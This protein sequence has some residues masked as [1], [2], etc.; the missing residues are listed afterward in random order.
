MTPIISFI[1]AAMLPVSCLKWKEKQ[2]ESKIMSAKGKSNT[3]LWIA[4]AVIATIVIAGSINSLPK[5]TLSSFNIGD[6]D[7]VTPTAVPTTSPYGDTDGT[8]PVTRKLQLSVNDF[9]AGTKLTSKTVYVYL[10]KTLKDTLTTD[11]TTGLAI[12]SKPWAS[13]TNLNLYYVDGNSKYWDPLEVPEMGYTDAMSSTYNEVSMEPFT[14]GTYSSDSLTQGGSAL[15]DTN[16]YNKTLSGNTPTFVYSLS[17]TGADN[18]GLIESYDPI[19]EIDLGAW[20]IV[21]LTGTDATK[22]VLRSGF[23]HSYTVGTD[24]Y[25]W[26]HV[27]PNL[28]SK[29]T[30]GSAYKAGYEG[31][32]S[33]SWSI[34][35]TGYSADTADM[36]VY[37]EMYANPTY[38]Q[39]HGGSFGPAAVE[40][41][42]QTINIII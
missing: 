37:F 32:Q 10:G 12:T 3:I 41:A 35:T 36:Q 13:G 30:E 42:E 1:C 25:G 11:G 15:A 34:D 33:V 21:K 38:A 31:I 5:I 17:N 39:T 23:T 9:F 20:V 24:V 2:K 19:N 26:I 4:V 29:W 6:T 14:I 16:D 40:L 7:D 22:V 18:T 27:N 8:D 28:L